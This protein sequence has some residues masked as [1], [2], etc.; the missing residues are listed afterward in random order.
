MVMERDALGA[1]MACV[2]QSTDCFRS[3]RLVSI[4]VW[5][6][7]TS[8]CEFEE[9]TNDLFAVLQYLSCNANFKNVREKTWVTRLYARRPR[10]SIPWGGGGRGEGGRRLLKEKVVGRYI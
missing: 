8:I 2:P 3:L 1:C 9:K 10:D 7:Q 4:R 6:I 5:A